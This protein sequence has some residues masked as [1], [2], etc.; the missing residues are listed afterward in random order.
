MKTGHHNLQICSFR[1]THAQSQTYIS[2]NQLKEQIHMPNLNGILDYNEYIY[3]Q[4]LDVPKRSQEI[5]YNTSSPLAGGEI[6]CPLVSFCHS[7]TQL[8][9][10]LSSTYYMTGTT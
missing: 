9:K 3:W 10:Y 7:G 4:L 6:W 5:E 8:N 2:N 1:Y